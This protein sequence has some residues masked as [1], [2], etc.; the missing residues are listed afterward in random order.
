M[1]ASNL[2]SIDY[3]VMEH[4]FAS[5]NELGRLADENVFQHNLLQRLHA[6]GMRAT[7]E[8]SADLS[9]QGFSIPLAID[10]IVEEK[11]IYELKCVSKLLPVHE[12]QLLGYMFMTNATHGK[13][14][15]TFSNVEPENF[16][17]FRKL[18]NVS[19]L[20]QLHWLNVTHDQVSLVT[21]RRDRKI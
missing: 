2:R 15:T 14:V 17:E 16:A 3:K 11:V 9:F 10:L 12:G 6:A 18:L 1:S 13:L 19:P 20:S 5:H 7:I 4:A 21:I 8:V